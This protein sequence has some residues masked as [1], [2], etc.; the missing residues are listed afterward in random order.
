[1]D[2]GFYSPELQRPDLASFFHDAAAMG[3]RTVQFN[4]LTTGLEEMPSRIPAALLR[5]I[6]RH[7]SRSAIRIVAVNGTFNMIH[8]DR[9]MRQLGIERF[10]VMADACADLDCPIVTLCT[11]SR[12]PDSMWRFH[13][14]SL[15]PQAW[16]DLRRSLEAI[17]PDAQRYGLILGIESEASNCVN[18]AGRARRLLDEYQTPHLKIIMDAANLFAPGQAEPEQVRP[19][20][21]EAFTLLGSDLCLAHGKD[22][23]AGPGLSFTHAGDGIIDFPYYLNHLAESGY[24]DSFILHGIHDEANLESSLSFI[25][26]LTGDAANHQKGVM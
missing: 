10:H 18:S 12:H 4:F 19:V 11:G 13:P 5:Q 15:L 8:P 26:A 24:T 20:I 1:M 22:L 7:S 21:D 17:L 9:D 23:Q 2:I 16:D 14:D 25:Q 3:Y 6:I